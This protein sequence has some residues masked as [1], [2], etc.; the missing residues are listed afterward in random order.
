MKVKELLKAEKINMD[1]ITPIPVYKDGS[2]GI[3]FSH[4]K[5]FNEDSEIVKYEKE[6]GKE[7]LEVRLTNKFKVTKVKE[8]KYYVFW[9]FN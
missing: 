4:Y 9:K 8:D 3:P 1:N 2:F 7:A 5:H 6:M